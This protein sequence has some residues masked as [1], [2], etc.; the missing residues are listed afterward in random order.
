MRARL[1][2]VDVKQRLMRGHVAAEM[3]ACDDRRSRCGLGISRLVVGQDGR[4]E[5][6]RHGGIG[7]GPS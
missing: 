3:G 6:L 7:V 5:L 2:D 1:E 4:R